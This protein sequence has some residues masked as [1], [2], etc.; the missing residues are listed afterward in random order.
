MKTTIEDGRIHFILDHT[1]YTSLGNAAI[2]IFVKVFKIDVSLT[3]PID[4][5]PDPWK[6]M[7]MMEIRFRHSNVG[8]SLNRGSI[9][10]N[11]INEGNKGKLW[12]K[13]NPLLYEL[14]CLYTWPN[15]RKNKRG[16]DPDA[17]IDHS[18]VPKG[19]DFKC[20]H[21]EV[22]PRGYFIATVPSSQRHQVTDY[23][24]F[25]QMKKTMR[26]GY[27]LGT[28]LKLDFQKTKYVKK[29][30]VVDSNGERYVEDIDAVNLD[31]LTGWNSLDFFD[32][33]KRKK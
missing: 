10:G 17:F 1:E 24:C 3:V 27:H 6:R 15:M 4:T 30:G 16:F 9:I 11:K 19:V 29:A 5:E 33:V 25:G 8:T 13:V 12:Q 23:Y 31:Q 22:E 18:N 20:K 32:V 21:R 28:L 7:E 26:E 2:D 14:I